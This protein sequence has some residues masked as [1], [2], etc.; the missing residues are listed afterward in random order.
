MLSASGRMSRRRDCSSM[1]ATATPVAAAAVAAAADVSHARM[2]ASPETPGARAAAIAMPAAVPIAVMPVAMM[3]IMIAPAV[4]AKE[5]AAVEAAEAQAFWIIAGI[6]IGG[7]TVRVWVGVGARIGI[8][9]YR[10]TRTVRER[11]EKKKSGGGFKERLH[12]R[13]PL[14]PY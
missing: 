7:I 4:A 9:G 12:G 1:M 13:P 6:A 8:S 14:S 5:A 2:H 10:I 3:P 11:S